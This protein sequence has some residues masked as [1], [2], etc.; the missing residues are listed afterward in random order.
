MD[1]HAIYIL[2]LVGSTPKSNCRGEVK[3][4]QSGYDGISFAIRK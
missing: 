3:K 4:I 2:I 1:N